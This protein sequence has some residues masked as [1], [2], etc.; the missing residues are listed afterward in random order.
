MGKVIAVILEA[1]PIN[2]YALVDSVKDL[3]LG[4]VV[5]FTG[6]VRA[7][8]GDVDTSK[9][10]YE[11]HPSMAGAQMRKI[12][13]EAAEMWDANVAIAHRIGE[14]AP[15]ETAVVCV[16]AC[17]HRAQAFECC[18]HLIDRIKE[19]VPIWK[20]EFGASGDAW[21]VGDERKA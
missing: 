20:K 16:A 15:G 1:G 8:T 13:Y 3:H 17:A 11:A 12:A 7:V 6:E 18:R 19:D 21:I 2:V 5:T 9:L 10:I 4:G 14:L